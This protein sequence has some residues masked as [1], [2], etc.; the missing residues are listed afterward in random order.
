MPQIAEAFVDITARLEKLRKGMRQALGIVGAGM[1]KMRSIIGIAGGKMWGLFLGTMRSALRKA[2]A[3]VRRWARRIAFLIAGAFGV[4]VFV[5]TQFETAMAR[6]KAITGATEFEFTKLVKVARDLGRTTVFTARQVSEAMGF[7]ALA[8]FKV[9]EIIKAMPATLNLAAAGQLEMGVAADIASKIMRGMGLTADDLTQAMDVMTKAFTSANTNLIQLG[10]AMKFLGPIGRAAGKGLEELVASIQV[11]SDAGI[12]GQQAGVALRNILL[13][14]SGTSTEAAKELKRL[15]IETIDASGKLKPMADLIDALSAALQGAGEQQRTLSLGMIGG[16][17][18]V[19]ALSA[20]VDRGGDALRG[21]EKN[22]KSSAGTAERIA[23]IQLDTLGGKFI[24]VRSAAEDFAITIKDIFRP[25]LIQGAGN[26]VRVLIDMNDKVM[27]VSD[28]IRRVLGDSIGVVRRAVMGLGRAIRGLIA[29]LID[30]E[31]TGLDLEKSIRGAIIRMEFALKRIPLRLRE[32]LNLTKATRLEAGKAIAVGEQAA[33]NVQFGPRINPKTGEPAQ[34]VQAT[35]SG[36]KSVRRRQA[37][38]ERII[39]GRTGPARDVSRETV[40]IELDREKNRVL[41]DKSLSALAREI[42]E[43]RKVKVLPGP[44]EP[45]EKPSPG[46]AP[47]V[48]LPNVS[49]IG[50]GAIATIQTATGAFKVAV[51]TSVERGV[52]VLER[53]EKLDRDALKGLGETNKVLNQ[54]RQNTKGGPS[55]AFT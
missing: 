33:L 49:A 37:E 16:V 48:K 20:M 17:R 8:G 3:L 30:V 51:G 47:S 29:P 1:G 54:I 2:M 7:F 32:I 41:R 40:K 4:A 5:G 19:A 46:A 39:Q 42:R 28:S 43:L 36:G 10:D 12:Q 38:L 55:T 25:L 6:V 9:N 18:A 44:T 53:I 11:V 13:R 24:L 45:G 50:R 26:L 22:L 15:G 52:R 35:L 23:K 14:L 31:A 21:F 34:A 27:R